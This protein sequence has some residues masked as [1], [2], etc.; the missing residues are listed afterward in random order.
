MKINS[1]ATSIT[2]IGH[3]KNNTAQNSP[4]SINSL[5]AITFGNINSLAWDVRLNFF[6]NWFLVPDKNR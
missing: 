6:Y 4:M 5:T 3:L 2:L 1:K